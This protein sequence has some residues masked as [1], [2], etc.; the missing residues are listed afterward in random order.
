MIKKAMVEIDKALSVKRKG[1]R[2][3]KSSPFSMILQVHDELLFE[4]EEAEMQDLAKLVKDKMENAL[5][6]SVPVKV[7][8]KVGKNWGEM[9]PLEL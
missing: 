5:E 7:D 4:C 9:S 1:E 8:L 3:K 6:L 2:E